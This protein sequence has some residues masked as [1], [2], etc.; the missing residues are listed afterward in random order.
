MAFEYGEE[1]TKE[2]EDEIIEACRSSYIR[3]L[4][5]LGGEPFEKSNQVGLIS[6][7]RRFKQE[8]PDKD[9]WCYS[10]YLF[11]KDIINLV[12]VEYKL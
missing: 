5:L 9:I 4:S 10:G 1:F 3:G 2:V 11:D 8:F 6:L 12:L 7:V